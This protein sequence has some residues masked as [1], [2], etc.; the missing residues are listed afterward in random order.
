MSDKADAKVE[1]KKA[2]ARVKMVKKRRKVK[3]DPYAKY[4][5]QGYTKEPSQPE[6]KAPV[7]SAGPWYRNPDWWRVVIGVI[8]L[9]VAGIGLYFGVFR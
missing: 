2:K 7:I 3:R 1:K 9:V 4:L 5:D 8:S 6:G